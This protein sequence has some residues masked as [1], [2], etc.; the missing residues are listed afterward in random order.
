MKSTHPTDT[1]LNRL[2]TPVR[3]NVGGRVRLEVS[4]LYRSPRLKHR[5][6]DRL[7]GI[8][9]IRSVQAN[10]LT[11]RL[12]VICA[13][14]ITLA[15]LVQHIELQLG[16]TCATR[17]MA[18][19]RRRPLAYKVSKALNGLAALLKGASASQL[20]A[21]AAGIVSGSAIAGQPEKTLQAIRPW[22]AMDLPQVIAQL[23]ASDQRGL[24]PEEAGLR[25]QQ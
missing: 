14:Q 24:S 23:N 9:G 7:S 6:E 13:P 8:Q 15:E 16:D 1:A 2:V 3:A 12:L 22:Y 18:K 4:G 21:P 11:G 19:P 17:P 5:L 25:L 10:V 20:P